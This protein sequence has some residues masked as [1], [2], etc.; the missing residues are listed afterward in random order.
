MKKKVESYSPETGELE[1]LFAK[2]ATTCPI[3]GV[4]STPDIL[5]SV[6]FFDPDT[7][8]HQRMYILNHCPT[9]D[10]CFISQHNYDEDNN[11][12]SY[13]S[14]APSKVVSSDFS[15]NMRKLSPDFVTIYE[16]SLQAESLGLS[17]ICGMGYRKSLEYLVKDYCISNNPD[18]ADN[19]SALP[20]AKCIDQY[21]DDPRLKTLAKASS[22]LGN[23]EAHYIKK[24]PAYG[25]SKLKAFINAFV[26]FVEREFAYKE[27]NDLI[28]SN[29]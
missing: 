5:Y 10:E 9:C 25:I 6:H 11:V 17:T 14:S 12:F 2:I 27:A 29:R 8:E 28:L 1:V 3:C 15:E 16:D 22:W 18:D 24:H 7:D 19:I 20:L 23:D 26:S 21:I 13:I 4:S